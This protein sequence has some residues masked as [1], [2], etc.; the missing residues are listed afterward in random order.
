MMPI[1]EPSD[2]YITQTA[3]NLSTPPGNTFDGNPFDGLNEIFINC[4]NDKQ[5][6]V[7]LHPTHYGKTAVSPG[8]RDYTEDELL[9]LEKRDFETRIFITGRIFDGD[10]V[11]LRTH[12]TDN[13]CH[14]SVFRVVRDYFKAAHATKN[15]TA[16]KSALSELLTMCMEGAKSDYYSFAVTVASG[17]SNMA[18]NTSFE[19]NRNM[20]KDKADLPIARRRLCLLMHVIFSKISSSNFLCDEEGSNI[21][22][23]VYCRTKYSNMK[24]IRVIPLF[25]FLL[26]VCLTGFVILENLTE[27]ITDWRAANIPLALLTFF[28]S[29]LVAWP[30]IT[31]SPDAF[32]V[33]KRIG[34]IQ[35]IDFVVNTI[36]PVVLLVSGFFVI[37]NSNSYIES[38]L[39]TAALLFIP[40]IDDQL[41]R[42][43]GFNERSIY[44][45]YLMS[46]SLEELDGYW[47]LDDNDITKYY[48]RNLDESIGVQ[49]SDFYL[50]NWPEQGA[51]PNKG[52]HFYPYR[53]TQFSEKDNITGK[54]VYRTQISPSN[55]VTADCLIRRVRWSYTTGERF[56]ATIKPRIGYLRLEL[57][58]G[59]V[60]EINMRGDT[61][62]GVE[63]KYHQ[64]DG[65]F[66]I[67]TFEMSSAILRLRLCGS[68]TASDFGKAIDYYSLWGLSF[69]AKKLL[70]DYERI[71]R[72]RGK[73]EN[74]YT[75]GKMDE[76]GRIVSNYS[77]DVNLMKVEGSVNDV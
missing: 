46:E 23:V 6:F 38:V 25:S 59:K 32:K 67:T 14:K 49:F 22:R 62:I 37:L 74:T 43:L 66:I 10:S 72:S 76:L 21:Y 33:Y 57:L 47:N 51:T 7:F 71:Q 45:N 2:S 4:C 17:L 39:N 52:I 70:K 44:M 53:I 15:R 35:L 69:E 73:P 58:N 75:M 68:Y 24:S 41:P 30:S 12:F 36:L 50:T 55:F 56:R 29:S 11:W 13:H 42:L 63:E 26:Q 16:A 77:L 64:L 31:E 5:P 3:S 1:F 60:M 19:I 34:P 27:G 65:V 54:P 48:L 28:Y 20:V 9:A 8:L 61:E 40:E 18:E